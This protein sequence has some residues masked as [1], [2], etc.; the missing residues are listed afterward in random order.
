MTRNRNDI[1]IQDINI[2]KN[3]R[4]LLRLDWNEPTA[5]NGSIV[6][7]LRI[8]KTIPFIEQLILIGAT[9]IIIS[10]L[11]EKGES[12]TH[13]ADFVKEKIPFTTFIPN[14][15]IGEVREAL[16]DALSGHVYI[17]ENIRLFE[18][19]L[20]NSDAL[21]ARLGELAD[22]YINDAFSVSHRKQASIVS[23]ATHTLSFAGPLFKKEMDALTPLLTPQVPA[24]FIIGGAKIKTK[25][26]LI[27]TY[28]AKDTFVF[29]GGAMVHNILKARGEEIGKSLYDESYHVPMD[30]INHPK[31]IVPVDVITE[32]GAH[33]DVGDIPPSSTIVDCG[34]K[35][36]ALVQKYIEN[37][38]TII[39]NGPVGLYEKGFSAGTET[40][41]YL[42]SQQKNAVTVLGGGDTLAVFEHM[43]EKGT[44]TYVSLS[45]GAMLT[46]LTEGTL[47]GIDALQKDVTL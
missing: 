45:G 47:E 29:V 9:V 23:L 20:E 28:L 44:F 1:F 14:T 19:E 33:Y 43:K 17:L 39:M 13:I 37:S 16:H 21:G 4:V 36:L 11:G 42:M 40:L 12:L 30:I 46:Y 22:I 3:K 34:T 5:E 26:T 24:L 6:E 2:C 32:D 31:L 25:L 27:E 8:V 15:D 10:H 35:T 41:L 38:K 7:S 18:G